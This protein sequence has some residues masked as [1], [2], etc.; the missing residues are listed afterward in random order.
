MGGLSHPGN[1][2]GTAIPMVLTKYSPK[3][4]FQSSLMGTEIELPD[5]SDER[6]RLLETF[7]LNARKWLLVALQKSPDDM[8]MVLQS[9]LTEIDE[10]SPFA[11]HAPGR[12]LA[13]EIGKSL[14]ANDSKACTSIVA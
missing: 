5:S 1:G 13:V 6:K 11:Q 9:Y 2:S 4:K 12:Q 8:R 10:S 3:F 14:P 7:H